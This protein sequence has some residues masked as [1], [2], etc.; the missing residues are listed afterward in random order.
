[1]LPKIASTRKERPFSWMQIVKFGYIALTTANIKE[2]IFAWKQF[3]NKSSE[4]RNVQHPLARFILQNW[5]LE[6]YLKK[7]A[8]RAKPTKLKNQRLEKGGL[9]LWTKDL[10]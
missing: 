7:F 10:L 4:S 9:A 1:M 6:A 3:S 2:P 8:Q 5:I